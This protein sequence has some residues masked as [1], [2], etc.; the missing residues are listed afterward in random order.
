M[1]FKQMDKDCPCRVD[2][3]ERAVGCH[4]RCERYLEYRARKD[5]VCAARGEAAQRRISTAG[6]ERM[7]QSYVN[8]QLKKR[9]KP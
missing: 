3:P 2:C 7:K 5:E 4:G 1:N 6:G 8:R 9:R